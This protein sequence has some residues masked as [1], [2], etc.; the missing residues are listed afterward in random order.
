MDACMSQGEHLAVKPIA[1]LARLH[2]SESQLAEYTVQL[3]Q[4]LGYVAK[5]DALDVT[6]VAPLAHPN[7]IFDIARPDA[8]L[9]GLEVAQFQGNAP[10]FAQDQFS[11]PKVV[12]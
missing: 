11:V 3:E 1:H 2:L 12:E 10:H 8:T 9:P 4:I 7:P 6:H 5:L